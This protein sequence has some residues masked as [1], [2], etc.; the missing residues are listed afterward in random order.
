[1]FRKPLISIMLAFAAIL[2][3]RVRT[4]DAHGDT[5]VPQ[6][7]DG[8]NT[9]GTRFKTKL[10][11]SNLSADVASSQE[12]ITDLRV[13]FFRQD[14][15]AWT[16]E[17]NQGTRSDFTFSLYPYQTL[18]IETL[19]TGTSLLTGYA[20]VRNVAGTSTYSDGF[21]VSV[22]VFYEISRSSGVIDTVSVPA[23]EATNWFTVPIETDTASN[24]L[25]GLAIVNLDT[26]SSNRV[27]LKLW[28]AVSPSSGPPRPDPSA[29]SQ[30]VTLTLNAREQRARFLNETG[31]YPTRT[32]VKG[33]LEGISDK[34]VAVVALLQSPSSTGVQYATLTA[35]R[36]DTLRTNSYLYLRQSTTSSSGAILQWGLDADGPHVDYFGQVNEGLDP[37]VP[38][39]DVTYDTISTTQRQLA[40]QSGAQLSIIGTRNDTDFDRLSLSDLQSRTY[41]SSAISLNDS[42]TNFAVTFAFAVKTNLG[43]YAKVRVADIIT[44]AIDTT[45]KHLVLEVFTFR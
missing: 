23:T 34:P 14:G 1:M 35:T 13:F 21:K 41:S 27:R 37:D 3:A 10:D 20:I 32:R 4:A 6:V 43:R 39:W 16:I 40:A 31:L 29:T 38:R 9:D 25:S 8:L 28:E 33:L 45:L 7:A 15:T 5:V 42:S 2:A 11:I 26:A 19:G 30:F 24:L 36:K 17:T 22:S 44:D 12:S 18:R